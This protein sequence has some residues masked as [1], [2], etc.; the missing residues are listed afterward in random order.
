MPDYNNK[1][2]LSE[3]IDTNISAEFPVVNDTLTEEDKLYAKKV[4]SY[5]IHKCSS[6]SENS[7][8][9]ED[10]RCSK[11]FTNNAIQKNTTFNERGFP[12]YKRSTEKCLN[13]VPH[14]RNI[15]LAWDGHANVEFAGSTF[16]V[17]YLYK[18]Y[19]LILKFFFN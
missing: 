17:L 10:G 7:C 1:I 11:T 18:V 16:L 13:V 8:L 15:L 5:M 14:N 9:D 6:G 4:E 2:G 19:N 12:Q 3:W